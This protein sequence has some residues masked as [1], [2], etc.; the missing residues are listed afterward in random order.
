MTATALAITL[1]LAVSSIGGSV[2]WSKT[3]L[4]PFTGT[5]STPCAA[6]F[7]SVNST[8][9]GPSFNFISGQGAFNVTSWGGSAG[10][11][12]VLS[13]KHTIREFGESLTDCLRVAIYFGSHSGKRV[14]SQVVVT[15]SYT[16]AANY[17]FAPGI[18]PWVKSTLKANE[19]DSTVNGSA[20]LLPPGL[21][22][23]NSR[24]LFASNVTCLTG[25][26]G[27]NRVA[28]GVSAS[29]SERNSSRGAIFSN[30]STPTSVLASGSVTYKIVPTLPLTRSGTLSVALFQEY[31][32]MVKFETK[33]GAGRLVGGFSSASLNFSIVSISIVES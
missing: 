19:C 27:S 16:I 21:S 17:S 8:A 15:I 12:N 26:T 25:C 6:R 29:V 7:S 31:S 10:P 2:A 3:I 23:Q 33:I 1:M 13:N 30:S 5:F 28:V 22:Y 20:T 4:P 14:L 18:C 11:A 24:H 9:S 32:D